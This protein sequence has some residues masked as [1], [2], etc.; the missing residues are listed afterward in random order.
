MVAVPWIL[1]LVPVGF[2]V[3]LLWR[4]H[5]DRVGFSRWPILPVILSMFICV[6]CMLYTVVVFLLRH[7]LVSSHIIH[8]SCRLYLM[9]HEWSHSLLIFLQG[10][11]V[12]LSWS[13]C[14]SEYSIFSLRPT[15]ICWCACAVVWGSTNFKHVSTWLQ[16]RNP[17]SLY[18]V[19]SIT[20]LS[21]G[22]SLFSL[23]DRSNVRN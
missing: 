2:P 19:R 11:P 12:T 10:T 14:E 8:A 17:R 20:C 13:R 9:T 7:C 5:F 1:I 4:C 18:A 6:Q 16:L 22:M 23:N 21:M 3:R 15:N